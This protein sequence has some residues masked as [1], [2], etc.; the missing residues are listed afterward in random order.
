MRLP[1][2]TDLH[3]EHGTA[4]TPSPDP[5]SRRPGASQGRA[6]RPD[7]PRRTVASSS[8]FTLIELIVVGALISI[9]LGVSVGM[10]AGM[11]A[12]GRAAAT[13]DT[14]KQ[15]V[16]AWT[17]HLQTVGEWPSAIPDA[18]E[19]TPQKTSKAHLEALNLM[20]GDDPSL[21]YYFLELKEKEKQEG[22]K[23]SWGEL[24]NV[25]L[26]T[27]YDGQITHPTQSETLLKTSVAVLSWGE[28]RKSGTKDDILVY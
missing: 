3:P 12:K 24:F 5:L 17:R 7:A 18:A 4:G 2:N 21:G 11:K 15:L 16:E 10:L 14:A 23:D 13:R 19:T 26:D 9:L 28:D 22:L 25:Y 20:S 27:D 6:H 1:Q 8:G